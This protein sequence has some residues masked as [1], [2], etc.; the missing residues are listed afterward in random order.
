MMMLVK[1]PIGF[2]SEM[3]LLD[4]TQEEEDEAVFLGPTSR[5]N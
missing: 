2:N 1:A 3:T 4:R 5:H